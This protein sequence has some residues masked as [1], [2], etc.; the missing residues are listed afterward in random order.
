[1]QWKAVQKICK[2][3]YT[4]KQL[5]AV[6]TVALC[7]HSRVAII[8]PYMAVMLAGKFESMHETT[9]YDIT[10]KGFYPYVLCV[11]ACFNGYVKGIEKYT[12]M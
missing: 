5:Q 9:L 8:S 11:C 6:V 3:R 12:N 4:D 2:L 1:M 10:K 7:L